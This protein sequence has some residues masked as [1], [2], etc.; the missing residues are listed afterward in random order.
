MAAARRQAT[1]QERQHSM[2]DTSDSV[3]PVLPVRDLAAAHSTIH[4][5]VAAR[6]ALHP[7]AIALRHGNRTLDYRQLDRRA[8]GLAG[9][10]MRRGIGPGAVIGVCL[11]RSIDQIVALFA[12]LKCGCAFLALDPADPTARR[13]SLVVDSGAAAV[14]TSDALAGDFTGVPIVVPAIDEDEDIATPLPQVGGEDLAYVVYTSGSTGTPN[15]VEITHANLINF[16]LWT[17]EA[18]AVTAADVASHAIGLTFDVAVSET[19]PYLAAGATVTLVDEAVRTA[20]ELMRQWLL[21]ERVTIATVPMTMTELMLKMAWPA[22]APLRLM[23]TGGDVLRAYPRDDLPFDLVNNYGPSECTIVA[24]YGVVP[25]RVAGDGDGGLPSIGRPI[26]GVIIHLLDA[27]GQPVA[28]G[29]EGEIWIGGKGVGRGY[30]GRPALTAAR[31]RS[32]PFVDDPA[33][34][35][36]RT[37][38]RG[39]WLVS[40]ELA[41]CGRIDSQTKIRGVRI[42]LDEVALALQR[43]PAVGSAVVIARDDPGRERYLAAYVV[44][45]T[46][47]APDAA[48]LR[49]FLGGILPQAY[50]PGAIVVLDRMPLTR[51]GKVDYAAL[52][53]P[54]AADAA[55]QPRRPPATVTQQRLAA[56]IAGIL[57]ID[58]IAADDDFFLRGGHSILATQVVI[59]SRAAFGVELTLRDLFNAPTIEGFAGVI[60]SRIAARVATLSAEQVDAML[61]SGAK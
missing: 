33:A 1:R 26:S 49:A 15:G 32:D 39:H 56:I 27:A 21:D 51:H 7:D 14:I 43:H 57:S 5:M 46:P 17:N 22:D 45:A 24:T 3:S 4:E 12:V 55:D 41:F 38:D 30:R 2:T 58:D 59:Q 18:F 44:P 23:L 28:R 54:A 61:A 40:G 16:V 36:Y 52:P 6:A 31:F 11:D 20:P 53:L 60:E 50:L 13:Q 25:R 37:G 19:W 8:R 29:E 48:A 42:E 34:R 10:L 47:V 9:T 35:M